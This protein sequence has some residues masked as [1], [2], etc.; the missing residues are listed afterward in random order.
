MYE[1][2]KQFEQK[3]SSLAPLQKFKWIQQC[4]QNICKTV[5]HISGE[6]YMIRNQ[7]S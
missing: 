2:Q 6:I 7:D 4:L 3:Q 5:T 1:Q